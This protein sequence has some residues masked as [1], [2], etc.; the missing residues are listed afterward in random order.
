MPASSR[1]RTHEQEVADVWFDGLNRAMC[2]RNSLRASLIRSGVRHH[3]ASHARWQS[4]EARMDQSACLPVRRRRGRDDGWRH[5]LEI[6]MGSPNGLT[7][8]GWTR[9]LLKPGDAVTVEG[10]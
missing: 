1:R 3:E 7:R 6:E 2:R 8:L 9:N 10:Y 4:D 5:Q